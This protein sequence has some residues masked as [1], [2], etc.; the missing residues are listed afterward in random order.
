MQALVFVTDDGKGGTTGP[1]LFVPDKPD[2]AL[3]SHPRSLEWCYFATI[4]ERDE[5][6]DIGGREGLEL[7]GH[8]ISHRMI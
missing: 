2:V 8:Y 7:D 5:M 4:D 1:T 6:L 3:P